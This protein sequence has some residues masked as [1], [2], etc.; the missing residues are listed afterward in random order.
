MLTLH[1]V[2]LFLVLPVQFVEW[3]HVHEPRSAGIAQDTIQRVSVA[4]LVSPGAKYAP[5]VLHAPCL[6]PGYAHTNT[7][8]SIPLYITS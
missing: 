4:D 3:Q 1:V 7:F 6:R 2:F 8:V 5:S